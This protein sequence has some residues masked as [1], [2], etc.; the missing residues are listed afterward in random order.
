M[1]TAQIVKIDTFDWF[2]VPGSHVICKS[3]IGLDLHVLVTLFWSTANVSFLSVCRHGL[4]M[5]HLVNKH[6]YNDMKRCTILYTNR[7][8]VCVVNTQLNSPALCHQ[9]KQTARDVIDCAS[10]SRS[11]CIVTYN[12]S[13][14]RCRLIW[15]KR[16]IGVR[17]GDFRSEVNSVHT[18]I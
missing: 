1:Y 16:S 4:L 12:C 6:F 14:Y 3:N 2:C 13:S 5:Q 15:P 10:R 7:F 8:V 11:R 17:H 18:H 9:S